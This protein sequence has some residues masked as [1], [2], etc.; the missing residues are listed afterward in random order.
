MDMKKIDAVSLY[1]IMSGLKLTNVKM[2]G[3]KMKVV[4]MCVALKEI[5][6]D[7]DELVETAREMS[8]KDANKMI[9]EEAKAEC[10]VEIERIS[11]ELLEEIVSS[12][13]LTVGE[14]AFIT[15][16]IA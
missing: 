2:I 9:S 6:K 8:P 12:N 13:D 4:H 11:D 5:A 16:M 3:D 10:E 7:W 1:R 15:E 14:I